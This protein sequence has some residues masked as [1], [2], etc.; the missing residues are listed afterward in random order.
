MRVGCEGYKSRVYRINRRT[1]CAPGIDI[2][3]YDG[4]GLYIIDSSA[5]A[6]TNYKIS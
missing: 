3:F 6:W 2:L 1:Y 5:F 4:F